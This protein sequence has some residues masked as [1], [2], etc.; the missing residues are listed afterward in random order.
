MVFNYHGPEF[1]RF[2]NTIERLS[3]LDISM[4]PQSSSS[5]EEHGD[6]TAALISTK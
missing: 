4:S 2:P 3:K 5:L 1:L 6:M